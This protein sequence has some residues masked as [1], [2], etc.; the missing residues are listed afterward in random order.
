MN[1]L[2]SLLILSICTISTTSIEEVYENNPI[3]INMTNQSATS[4]F[5]F[6]VTKDYNSSSYKDVIIFGSPAE[7]PVGNL[8]LYLS[9]ASLDEDL[10]NAQIK[11]KNLLDY[12]PCV[13]SFSET[14]DRD[15]ISLYFAV[16]CISPNCSGRLK[17]SHISPIFLEFQKKEQFFSLRKQAEIFTFQ[18]PK[19]EEFEKVVFLLQNKKESS[20]TDSNVKFTRGKPYILQ[21]P[22]GGIM[23][24]FYKNDSSL[25]F[26]CNISAFITNKKGVLNELEVFLYKNITDISFKS[27]YY[28][29]TNGVDLKYF[30]KVPDEIYSTDFCFN[31]NLKSLSGSEKMLFVNPNVLPENKSLFLMNNSNKDFYYRE[32]NIEICK[33][34][35]NSSQNKGF[36]LVVSSNITGEF[37]L[38]IELSGPLHKESIRLDVGETGI[39]LSKEWKYYE[40]EIF[41]S[42]SEEG[43]IEASLIKSLGD[44][45]VYLKICESSCQI[46]TDQDIKNNTNL[47]FFGEKA[48]DE[49]WV[50][51]PQCPK[52]MSKCFYLF[53]IRGDDNFTSSHYRLLLKRVNSFINL[54]EN[55]KH[56]SH[57]AYQAEQTY[58][59][60]VLNPLNDIEMITF[61]ISGDLTYEIYKEGDCLKKKNLNII[62]FNCT[63]L[64]SSHSPIIL[65]NETAS[66][67]DFSGN[68]YIKVINQEKSQ[69]Y[70]VFV[71]VDRNNK[72]INDRYL[73]L[74]EGK[75]FNGVLNKYF[76]E[77][78]LQYFNNYKENIEIIFNL[79]SNNNKF[80]IYVSD[81]EETP[82]ETHYKWF[83]TQDNLEILQ[84]AS[85]KVI[86][87]YNILIKPV[88]LE[89]I[90]KNDS[91]QEFVFT[92]SSNYTL[93]LLNKNS[94]YFD[95]L[96]ANKS[97]Q[98]MF[99]VTSEEKKMNLIIEPLQPI[100]LKEGLEIY[101]GTDISPDSDDHQAY[102]NIKEETNNFLVIDNET[103]HNMCGNKSNI[104]KIFISMFNKESVKV[105]YSI[106]LI[107]E[108]FAIELKEANEMKV[109]L[110]STGDILRLFY[111]A[112]NKINPLDISLKSYHPS[113]DVYITI[114]NNKN[115][116]FNSSTANFPDNKSFMLESRNLKSHLIEVPE[117]GFVDCFPF[118]LVLISVFPTAKV[119]DSFVWIIIVDDSTRIYEKNSVF[120]SL[121]KDKYKYFYFDITNL[122]PN[123]SIASIQ[124]SLTHFLG[125]G[126]LYF[127]LNDDFYMKKPFPND[128]DYYSH[129][130]HIDIFLKDLNRIRPLQGKMHPKLVLCSFCGAQDCQFSLN[131]MVSLN[132]YTTVILGIPLEISIPVDSINKKRVFLY[133]NTLLNGFKVKFIRESG[134]GKMTIAFCPLI[135]TFGY[136]I[137]DCFSNKNNPS[138]FFASPGESHL[139]INK[140]MPSYCEFCDV[141]IL[142]ESLSDLKGSLLIVDIGD[143]TL[144]LEGKQVMDSLLPAEENKYRLLV[145]KDRDTTIKIKVFSGEPRVFLSGFYE[146]NRKKFPLTF[147]KGL[148]DSFITLKI[149]AEKDDNSK[150][151]EV[152][153]IHYLIITSDVPSNYSIVYSTGQMMVSLSY[154]MLESDFLQKNNSKSY[155]FQVFGENLKKYLTIVSENNMNS[156]LISFLYKENN[157]NQYSYYALNES[158]RNKNIYTFIIP[159]SII[160]TFRIDLKNIGSLNISYSM[161][162]NSLDAIFLPFGEKIQGIL[163]ANHLKYYEIL[164]PANGYLVLDVLE[165]SGQIDLSYTKSYKNLFLHQWDGSFNF[166]FKNSYVNLLKVDSGMYY[167]GVRSLEKNDT[168]VY[169]FSASFYENYQDI[170]QTQILPGGEGMLNIEFEDKSTAL[171]NY[172]NI[173]CADFCE[174]EEML[175]TY[176][177]YK[178]LISKNL[179]SLNNVGKCGV[180]EIGESKGDFA[181]L[182]LKNISLYESHRKDEI[183]KFKLPAFDK[184][185]NVFFNIKVKIIG[186]RGLKDFEIFYNDF[187]FN[188]EN[189]QKK[190]PNLSEHFYFFFVFFSFLCTV[191]ICGCGYHFWK[192]Y[193]KNEKIMMYEM[194]D[195]KNVVQVRGVNE[196]ITIN[197]SVDIDN[198]V[199]SYVG[200]VE[201]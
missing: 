12:N 119:P 157:Q 147:S 115:H 7:Y 73:K 90:Y 69:N 48:G 33:N 19:A 24:T 170:P 181:E 104:C 126:G 140:E 2:I 99:Y 186:F 87:K 156:L 189:I 70:I 4:S 160:G 63:F 22:N 201:E 123:I 165:C 163:N 32:N 29:R 150:K 101:L 60:S 44:C 82:S 1:L 89:N 74:S 198:P 6:Q 141:V 136:Q 110:N 113:F 16:R 180:Y 78:Y 93:K 102:L 176:L 106:N 8:E 59:L 143:F 162:L 152:K 105:F 34:D 199:K 155:M 179:K 182:S 187:V 108:E 103:L 56:E 117:K 200:L 183:E 134:V 53:A 17:I 68:Y 107:F 145:A 10:S 168:S 195:V 169:E 116:T 94:F 177:E 111:R 13:I 127:K 153:K 112:S 139:S 196:T 138:V 61:M 43:S 25:C 184:K 159:Q 57:I 125:T 174:K 71:R 131:L 129:D 30:F 42:D 47:S 149:N 21:L 135:K 51:K 144:L 65:N 80:F 121:Q 66:L 86:S 146:T 28:D 46:I 37:I 166:L 190:N 54:L 18:I 171:L 132:P 161:I 40:L 55:V 130:G 72:A 191:V 120:F 158:I 100:H 148:K 96:D 178:L 77:L 137:A 76:P 193:I 172:Y 9:T 142:V 64:G 35:F 98:F 122:I 185:A 23:A 26:N 109:P 81:D 62:G 175:E 5:I 92:I 97:L 124:F 41:H 118:C 84:S 45:K 114:Y 167:F 75:I 14:D 79:Q 49:I 154:G 192:K 58:K 88:D 39:I 85:E 27:E 91:S 38:N 128:Y 11:C 151:L 173:K 36:F 95:S 188:E 52:N 50:F 20:L 83:T 31:F 194:Q 67:Q 15:L 3:I 164:S 197:D 133:R